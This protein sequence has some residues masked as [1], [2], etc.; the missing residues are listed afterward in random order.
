M[1]AVCMRACA[2]AGVPALSLTDWGHLRQPSRP[3]GYLP[4]HIPLRAPLLSLDLLSAGAHMLFLASLRKKYSPHLPQSPFLLL[5][6][7]ECHKTLKLYIWNDTLPKNPV[8]GPCLQSHQRSDTCFGIPWKLKHG[9][10]SLCPRSPLVR[11][12]LTSDSTS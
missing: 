7:L 6:K 3:G 5:P 10:P 4:L 1:C 2:R 9:C 11:E 12:A 8:A